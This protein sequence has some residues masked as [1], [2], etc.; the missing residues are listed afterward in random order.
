VRG[1]RRTL[2]VLLDK[3]INALST[4]SA[5]S[6]LYW[7]LMNTDMNAGSLGGLLPMD[8]EYFRLA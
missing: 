7:M 1:L 2:N 5:D 4:V 6:N 3:C 8:V